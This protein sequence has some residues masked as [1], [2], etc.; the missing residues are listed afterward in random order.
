MKRKQIY[1]IYQESEYDFSVIRIILLKPVKNACFIKKTADS[2][3]VYGL[4]AGLLK[5]FIFREFLSSRRVF[6]DRQRSGKI[7]RE[8]NRRK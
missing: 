1:Q 5:S 3:I 7:R 4:A 2:C 6:N 8:C